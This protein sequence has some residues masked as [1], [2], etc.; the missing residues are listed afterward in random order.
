[1]AFHSNTHAFIGHYKVTSL[2]HFIRMTLPL[3][4]GE[5]WGQESVP[6]PGNEA[7]IIGN[8]KLCFLTPYPHRA[9]EIKALHIITL[10]YTDFTA[11]PL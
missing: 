6:A 4:N 5:V 9:L 10:S 8:I 11:T 3:L 2:S 7:E 1:M